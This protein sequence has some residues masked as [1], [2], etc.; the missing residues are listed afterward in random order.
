MSILFHHLNFSYSILSYSV[1]GFDRQFSYVT[2]ILLNLRW[3]L[4]QCLQSEGPWAFTELSFAS[5]DYYLLKCIEERTPGV[6]CFAYAGRRVLQNDAKLVA[7]HFIIEIVI[8]EITATTFTANETTDR[9]VEVNFLDWPLK[10]DFLITVSS[11][12]FQTLVADSNRCSCSL[13]LHEDQSRSKAHL[14]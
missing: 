7:G 9:L 10:N 3:C 2:L 6:S 13:F 1:E 14:S 5:C 4:H 8:V 11:S 12:L